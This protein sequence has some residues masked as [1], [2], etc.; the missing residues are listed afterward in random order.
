[1]LSRQA[2][3]PITITDGVTVS[4]NGSYIKVTGILGNLEYTF[5]SIV[6]IIHTNNII[7]L[8]T[9]DNTKFAKAMSG[10]VYAI[11][12]NMI[13]GVKHGFTKK[14][15]IIG[16]G[17][18]VAVQN[19]IL[20][21]SLGY[22]HP[23]IFNIPN[24]IKIETPTATEILVKGFD[25]HLVGEIAAK[26][27]GYRSVEPYKGKGIRYADEVVILKETKKK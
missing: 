25:K 23:I 6:N 17:Y 11:I 20:N 1:M 8:E 13:Y 26:I 9:K 21:L 27:R 16:V 15:T 2:K 4:A 12:N 5:N 18:K 24:G 10:T 19:S 22:S 3:L 7:T 14:L